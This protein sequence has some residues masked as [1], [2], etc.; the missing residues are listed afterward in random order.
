MVYRTFLHLP[1]IDEEFERKI[2]A[3]GVKDWWDFLKKDEI[4]GISKEKLVRLK[5]TLKRCITSSNDLTF[6]S[7]IIPSE[8]HWRLYKT[9]KDRVLYLD[10]ETDGLNPQLGTVTVI[11]LSDGSSYKAF[12][13]GRDLDQGLSIIASADIIVTF[14]GSKFD[15]PFLRAKYNWLPEPLIHLDL[16]ELLHR[17]GLRGGLKRIEKKLGIS[18]ANEVDGLDGYQAVKLWHSYQN[19]D[20]KALERLI[21]Y[22]REDVVNL[23]ILA[24]IAYEGLS[25]LTLTGK[26][27]SLRVLKGKLSLE[28]LCY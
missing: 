3:I 18:R 28:S 4:P 16:C 9:Y 14:G 26:L 2:W 5:D 1:G 24:E 22:N 13:A 20:E 11:G 19:G 27:P 7:A 12:I 8:H 25:Y 21:R 17:L 10:I 23:I 6:L 15:I